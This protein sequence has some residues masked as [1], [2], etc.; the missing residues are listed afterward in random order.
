[1]NSV[2]DPADGRI[3]DRGM[4][5]LRARESAHEKNKIHALAL[6]LDFRNR[7]LDFRHGVLETIR[8]ISVPILRGDHQP[9]SVGLF[10]DFDGELVSRF[11]VGEEAVEVWGDAEFGGAG[12]FSEAA[13]CVLDELLELE[14]GPPLGSEFF[15]SVS[16][17]P[18]AVSEEF[19]V[20]DGPSVVVARPCDDLV[21]DV[22]VS[23]SL[24]D[25]FMNSHVDG[26]SS[27]VDDE[28]DFIFPRKLGNLL[29]GVFDELG[30]RGFGLED[31]QEFSGVTSFGRIF[32]EDFGVDKRFFHDPVVFDFPYRR[33]REAPPDVLEV[34]NFLVGLAEEVLVGFFEEEAKKIG[35]TLR[36][37][38]AL[39][40][41]RVVQLHLES[42]FHNPLRV[43]RVSCV[44]E[45]HCDKAVWFG[46]S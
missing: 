34:G 31:E 23:V 19:V 6:V 26:P 20:D 22:I 4:E 7:A 9:V 38:Y 21:Q 18:C 41:L 28:D 32:G 10:V 46:F 35:D 40:G 8:E 16:G 15:P 14:K 29:L 17:A 42:R 25:D 45:C 24:T 3:S 43:K 11:G 5:E 12:G 44:A 2:R 1:M 27:G 39:F 36:D 13:F 33:H 30:H 37:G